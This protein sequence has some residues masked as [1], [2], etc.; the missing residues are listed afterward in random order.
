VINDL[1][2]SHESGSPPAFARLQL[3]TREE[4]IRSVESPDTEQKSM[5]KTIIALLYCLMSLLLTSFVMVFV[6]DRTPGECA[7]SS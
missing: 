4:L 6:H 3:F 1:A 2:K 7:L 5:L